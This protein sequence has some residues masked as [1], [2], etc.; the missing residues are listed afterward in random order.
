MQSEQSKIPIDTSIAYRFFASLRMT[1][2]VWD[3]GAVVCNNRNH[4]SSACG[5]LA[6]P[7][8]SGARNDK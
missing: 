4:N 1:N 5:F 6:E 8:L 7:A 2:G 3:S